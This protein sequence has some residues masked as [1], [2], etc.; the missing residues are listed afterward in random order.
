MDLNRKTRWQ[1]SL[2]HWVFVLLLLLLAS[3]LI[4]L[5]RTHHKS[6]D[7]TFNGRNSLSPGSA[8]VL[9][10]L[11]DPVEVTAYTDPKSDLGKGIDEFMAPYRRV[12]PDI[13]LRFIDPTEQ[14]E[15]TRQAGIQRN[16][17][18][19]VQYGKRSEH[20]TEL[21]ESSFVNLLLRLAREQTRLIMYLDGHGERKLDGSANHDLGE[22]GAQLTRRG[23]KSAPLNLA[24]AQEVPQNISLLLIAGP[25][26]DLLP[27][28]QTKLKQYIHNGGNLLWLLDTEPLHGLQPLAEQLDIALTPGVVIDPQAQQLNASATFAIGTAYARHPIFQNFNIITVFPFAREVLPAG[29]DRGWSMTP[30]IQVAPRGWLETGKLDNSVAFNKGQDKAGPITIALALER[31]ADNKNQRIVVIGDGNFLANQYLGNAG[32]LDLGM[33]IVNWLAGD[34]KLITLQPRVTRDAQIELTQNKKLAIV[35]GFLI[36]L[37]LAFLAAGAAVWWRRRKS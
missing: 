30:L 22:F 14:P 19:V 27:A 12:K 26:V 18:L 16:G 17:E 24:L 5:T 9:G 13:R 8:Q 21:D 20:L 15:I 10:K 35:I 33:N 28:E 37:P 7:I 11:K 23:F 3:L 6:W 1:L 31:K 36:V 25:R 2:H 29:S 4:A 32:N 34:E